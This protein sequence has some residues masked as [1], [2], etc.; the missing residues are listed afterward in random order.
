M[1]AVGVGFGR[2][3][4]VVPTYETVTNGCSVVKADTFATNTVADVD[5]TVAVC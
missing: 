5:S 1:S 4:N 2:G 3:D